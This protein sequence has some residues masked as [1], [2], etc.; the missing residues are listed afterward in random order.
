MRK[1]WIAMAVL[2][3]SPVVT[4]ASSEHAKKAATP[5]QIAVIKGSMQDTLKD[6]DSAKFRSVYLIKADVED[7]SLA[8]DV[9]GEVNAKNS[10]GGYTG[11][12]KFVASLFKG[13][14]GKWYA[15]T[16]GVDSDTNPAAAIMC[17]R[18][19]FD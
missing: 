17:S 8:Y 15:I 6:A 2:G 9:C 1:V 3:L 12:Q 11:Y 10:F 7:G 19:G 4:F 18:H 13:D 5:A 16:F 14:D